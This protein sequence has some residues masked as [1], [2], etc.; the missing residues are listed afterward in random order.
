MQFEQPRVSARSKLVLHS[1]EQLPVQDR[2]LFA[3]MDLAAVDDFTNVNRLR[4]SIARYPTPKRTPPRSL[5]P[6][7]FFLRVRMPLRSRSTASSRT[8]PSSR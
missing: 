1:V 5:P 2:L 7:S 6:L 3:G 8:E 4:R